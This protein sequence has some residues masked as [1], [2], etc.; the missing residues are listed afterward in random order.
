[1]FESKGLQDI[2]K[3]LPGK[4]V[5][6][7]IELFK[8]AM[9]KVAKSFDKT[10]KQLADLSDFPKGLKKVVPDAAVSSDFDRVTKALRSLVA[11][12]LEAQSVPT[13]KETE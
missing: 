6:K 5:E 2:L 3:E 8:D 1:M 12:S 9:E 11:V 10:G 13:T 7:I 4:D